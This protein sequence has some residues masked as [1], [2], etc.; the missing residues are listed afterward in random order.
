MVEKGKWIYAMVE[1]RRNEYDECLAKNDERFDNFSSYIDVGC[2][3]L[4]A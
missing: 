2:F 3:W 1:I 4:A